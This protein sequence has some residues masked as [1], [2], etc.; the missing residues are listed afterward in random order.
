MRASRAASARSGKSSRP[1]LLDDRAAFARD[2]Q[3]SVELADVVVADAVRPRLV[4]RQLRTAPGDGPA[5]G[6]GKD[7][8]HEEAFATG[9]T[10]LFPGS[11]ALRRVSS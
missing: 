8:A 7:R 1:R 9:E 4:C 3:G 2:G 11:A 5:D 6:L 10:I